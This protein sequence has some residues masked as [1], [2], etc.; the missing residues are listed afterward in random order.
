MFSAKLCVV[1]PEYKTDSTG[2]DPQ[3]AP[4][5]SIKQTHSEGQYKTN[6]NPSSSAHPYSYCNSDAHYPAGEPGR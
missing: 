4:S 3:Q 1:F 2:C 6:D 5:H